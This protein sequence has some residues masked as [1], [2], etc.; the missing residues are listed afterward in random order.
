MKN[1]KLSIRQAQDEQL[2]NKKV[3]S[4]KREFSAG[5]V[6][7]KKLSVLSSQFSVVF[8]LGK[9]SGYH[10]WVLPK[11]LIEK[12]LCFDRYMATMVMQELTDDGYAVIDIPQGI[13]T[14]GV[15]TKDFRGLV[16]DKKIIH[17]NNPVLNW[18]MGNAVTKK[19]H[20]D[21]IMLDKGKAT[22]RIDPVA[23]LINAH[24]RVRVEPKKN[25]YESRG[26][27]IM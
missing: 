15:P 14:L 8:L 5:G 23:S 18:A 16:Y 20:N 27:R 4:S 1:A 13:P 11:G 22:Q 6:V 10:K 3:L 26:M 21:N 17:N 9:H 7:F 25:I 12:E 24:V 2:K 19:D